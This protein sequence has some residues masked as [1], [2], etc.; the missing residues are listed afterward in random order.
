VAILSLPSLLLYSAP[1]FKLVIHMI[2][3]KSKIKR[4]CAVTRRLV[5]KEAMKRQQVKQ[6]G[7]G[8]N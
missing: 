3:Q 2:S 4:R 8:I 1:Q 5:E 7:R 6:E